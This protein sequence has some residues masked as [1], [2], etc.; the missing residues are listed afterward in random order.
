MEEEGGVKA[1]GPTFLFFFSFPSLELINS[2]LGFQKRDQAAAA[3][4]RR[5]RE[6]CEVLD[7]FDTTRKCLLEFLPSVSRV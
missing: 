2:A 4:A 5:T 1:K 6:R 3:A 7:V